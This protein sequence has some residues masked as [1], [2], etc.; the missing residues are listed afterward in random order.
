MVTVLDRATV[1]RE[2]LDHLRDLRPRVTGPEVLR[3]NLSLRNDVL[4]SLQVVCQA[5]FDIAGDFSVRRGLRFKTYS[6]VIRNL[7]AFTEFPASLAQDLEA[8]PDLRD[9]IVH[10]F[11]TLDYTRVVEALDHLEPIEQFVE[12]VQRIEAAS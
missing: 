3:G 9:M 1:L 7:S 5:L 8:L 12:I 6:E 10:R 4:R 2:H 11:S